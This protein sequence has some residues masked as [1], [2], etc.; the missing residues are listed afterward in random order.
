MPTRF[1]V[2][3]VLAINLASA[4]VSAA[5]CKPL[6]GHSSTQLSF[7][8]ENGCAAPGGICT[9][10]FVIGGLQGDLELTAL[11]QQGG[12]DPRIPSVIRF[13]GESRITMADGDVLIGVDTGAID[14]FPPQAG[15]V[16]TLITWTG[17]TGKFASASGH[18]VV[19]GV[20]DFVS[21]IVR[22]DYRGE[23]CAQ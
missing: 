21:R 10:G 16:G 9:R 12:L 7:T 18:I 8:G 23:V 3:A 22:T 13:I 15:R 5:T 19:D 11:S 17:G 4:H 20:V 2:L 6:N 1:V 14:T